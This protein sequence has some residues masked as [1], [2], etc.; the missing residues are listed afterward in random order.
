MTSVATRAVSARASSP[1]VFTYERL[2]LKRVINATCH[3]TAFGGTVMWPQVIEAM[4]LARE[5]CV[6]MK[7]LLDRASEIISA[8]T[9]AEASYVV[10]GCAA[11]LTV[12]AA[13]IMTGDDRRKMQALPHTAGLMKREFIARRHTRSRAAD[14]EEY[15][16]WGYAHAVRGAGGEFKEVGAPG[17]AHNPGDVT[18]EELAAAFGPET[19]GVYWV[20][21]GLETGVPLADVI[22]IAH[23]HGVPV[24]VDASNT[25]PPAE[26]LH[27]FIDMGADLVAFSGGKGLRGPQ[28][29]G[30][31][32]GRADLIRSARM[33]GAPTQGIGRPLKVSKEEIVGLLTALEIWVNRDHEADLRDAK[34]R[35]EAVVQAMADVPGVRAEHRFPDHVGRPYPTAFLHLDP[36]RGTAAKAIEALLHGDPSVAVMSYHDPQVIR[37]DVR[38]VSDAETDQ[39]IGRLREVLAA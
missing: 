19:A 24:L 23:S 13:A 9:H 12:G 30:I 14:G 11:G 37:V 33:Q 3:H 26:N 4:A 2:E 18:H 22:K 27:A 6:D 21:D 5:S 28:G 36:S 17:T 8:Y 38:I 10:S 31:L 29:S 35:T 20:S 15:A 1:A 16:N 34:R 7:A 25:L 32:T 39:V